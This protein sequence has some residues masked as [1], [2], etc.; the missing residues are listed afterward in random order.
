MIGRLRRRGRR[1]HLFL[2]K[3]AYLR[4]DLTAFFEVIPK[5]GG[6]KDGF[7]HSSQAMH[8]LVHFIEFSFLSY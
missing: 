5:T 8:H 6:I 2:I 7:D 1:C 4:L 3:V